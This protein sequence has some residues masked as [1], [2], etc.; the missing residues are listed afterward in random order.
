M[1]PVTAHTSTEF[2]VISNSFKAEPKS[3]RRS[4]RGRQ[5]VL[6]NDVD[7]RHGSNAAAV[8]CIPI[9][10]N[11]DIQPF[12]QPRDLLAKHEGSTM[13]LAYHTDHALRVLI[14]VGAKKS[15]LSTIGEIAR[16][17]GISKERRCKVVHRLS[18][19]D[20]LRTVQGRHGGIELGRPPRG[21]IGPLWRLPSR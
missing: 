21:R 3:G 2:L 14:F 12:R 8:R 16:G 1:A 18:Q 13:R 4:A 10:N 15:G 6:Q 20:Y 11:Q 19:L 5:G 17:Y 9:G 7:H